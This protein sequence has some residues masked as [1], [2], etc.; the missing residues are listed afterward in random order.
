M[1]RKQQKR[2]TKFGER[3]AA[4]KKKQE[5]GKQKVI[6]GKKTRE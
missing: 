4:A 3:S 5:R 2:K 1:K 6:G